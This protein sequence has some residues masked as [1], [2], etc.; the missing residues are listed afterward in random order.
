MRG[1]SIKNERFEIIFIPAKTIIRLENA[2]QTLL[3]ICNATVPALTYLL[4]TQNKI[5][6]LD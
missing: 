6:I 5:D 4:L 1:G 2:R 3:R